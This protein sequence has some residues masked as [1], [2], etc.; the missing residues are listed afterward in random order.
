VEFD[1]LFFAVAIPA[2]MIA[3][4]AKGGFG[5]AATFAATP[6]LA[7]VLEPALALGLMLPLLMMMDVA[8]LKAYWRRWHAPSARVLILG[9]VPGI[10][11]G[12][13][14]YRA[15]DPDML[16]FLIGAVAVAFVAFQTVRWLGW[17]QLRRAEFSPVKGILAGVA[18]GFASFVSHAGGPPVLMFL[19]PQGLHKTMFQATTVVMFFAVNLIK[20]VPYAFLGFFTAETLMANVLLAPVAL[21]GV[22]VGVRAHALVPETLFFALTHVLLLVVGARLIWVSLG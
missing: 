18:S 21:G 12:A 16:R 1:L 2:V 17:L 7:L 6:I 22:W 13:A 11:L 20:V 10:L 4:I 15:T 5:G 19:L 8:A 9:A 14:F 3:G